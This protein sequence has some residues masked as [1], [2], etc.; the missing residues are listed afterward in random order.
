MSTNPE[1]PINPQMIEQARRQ[2]NRLADEIARLS[3]ADLEPPDYY[4]EFLQ[5]LLAAIGAP[6]G[7]V[8]MLTPQGNLQLQFQVRMA[9]VGLDA[10]SEAKQTHDQLLRQA[11]RGNQPLMLAPQS[12]LAA[13][14]ENGAGPGNPTKFM[15]LIVPI[16]VDRRTVGLVEVW[17]DPNRGPDALRGYLNFMVRMAHLASGYARNHRLR[18]MNTQ[19]E[20]WT[21]LENFVKNVHA[22]L[23][24]TE[25]AYQVANEGRRL[26]ECDRVS[27]GM[28]EGHKMVV[29]AVSGV[30]VV[31]KRSNLVVLMR[32]LF[33]EVA[34]WG[35]KLVYTGTKDESLPP[36][37]LRALDDYLEESNSKTLIVL[38]IRDSREEKS[39]SPP[40]SVLMI[41]AFEPTITAEQLLSRVDV[42]AKH[43]ASALYNAYEYRHIPFRFL[44]LPL[45]RV[46]EGLGGKA[47]A[48]VLAVTFSVVALIT[49]MVVVPYPLKM[50]AKGMLLPIERGWIF[51]PLDGHIVS[52]KPEGL[53]SGHLV[54][55]GQDLIEMHSPK[56]E[57]EITTLNKDISIAKNNIDV[58]RSQLSAGR[59]L[60]PARR[61]ELEIKLIEAIATY[62][63]KLEERESLR[64]RINADVLR[65]G[66]FW[67]RPPIAGRLL[68]SDFRET[69]LNK[70]VKPNEPLLLIGK[71]PKGEADPR[72]W[73]I[74]L[75]IPQKHIGHI[76]AAYDALETDELDVDFL[77]VSQPTQVFRGKLPRHKIASQATPDRTDNNEAQSVVLAQVRLTGEG[78]DPTQRVPAHL[79]LAGT[80]AHARIHCGQRAMGYSL[81]YGVWEFFYE[82]IVFFF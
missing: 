27:V 75:K 22:S 31:E 9:E 32:K 40:R 79:L 12:G 69:L 1:P 82:N 76:L 16:I 45:A 30:D 58:Y 2:V 14:G 37:V 36:R 18:Q 52:I 4:R 56:V 77:L 25:V 29:K 47:K 15:N 78:I 53:A 80:E 66:Y 21:Q 39:S 20:V 54:T 6:A 19:Q 63:S 64:R 43:A 10:A 72:D 23:N 26:I 62:K 67:L 3:E 42:V 59:D 65:P 24:P 38:P 51:S 5:R 41:E 49:M 60:D 74:E 55:P 11:V 46:Q 13:Q 61:A 8:W 68:T 70:Y 50:D 57:A 7:A 35:E 71:L 33:D 28:R 81:F 17:Q 44:W 73:E 34:I 48:I